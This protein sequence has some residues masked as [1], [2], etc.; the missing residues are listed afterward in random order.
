MLN[1]MSNNTIGWS[2]KKPGEY[3]NGY[4][5][6]PIGDDSHLTPNLT[7]NAFNKKTVI[8]VDKPVAVVLWES[9]TFGKDGK[10]IDG[11]RSAMVNK[12]NELNGSPLLAEGLRLVDDIFIAPQKL[13]DSK[14]DPNKFFQVKKDSNGK[15]EV[16][17]I[18]RSGWE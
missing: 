8:G 9:N 15:F 17:S 18:P 7:G 14:E 13:R 11:Y 12:I 5:V 1:F 16:G 4:S 10:K 6:Y 2:G 3:S